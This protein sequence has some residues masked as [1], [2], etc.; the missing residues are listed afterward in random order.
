MPRNFIFVLSWLVTVWILRSR[1]AG[2]K[3]KL[4]DALYN[5]G[6]PII[7][8]ILV[9]GLILVQLL[10]AL[11]ALI[12]FSAAVA[13][14]FLANPFA[15]IIFALV[16]GGLLLLSL[17]WLVGSVVAL[18]VVTVPGMYPM[19]AVQVA[20][21]LVTSRRLRVIFRILWC[22]VVVLLFFGITMIPI[23][24]LDNLLKNVWQV[25]SLDI[26][27]VPV[28]LMVVSSIAVIFVASYIYLFYRHLVSREADKPE[29]P[30]VSEQVKKVGKGGKHVGAKKRR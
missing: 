1:L 17:Y 12:L 3:V 11:I 23:I 18:V 30:D 10:P 22:L 24:I 13:T 14:Q 8:T 15:A 2:H 27:I 25:V 9:V 19:K 26:P 20:G 4:R 6:A 16:A 28:T 7:S 5:A 29:L 21:D